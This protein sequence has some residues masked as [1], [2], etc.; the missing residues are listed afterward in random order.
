[1]EGA[2]VVPRREFG[3][4]ALAFGTVIEEVHVEEAGELDGGEGGGLPRDVE[5]DDGVRR[6]RDGVEGADCGAF[7]EVETGGG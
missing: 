3:S 4:D 7:V 5:A 6:E 2:G 1:M